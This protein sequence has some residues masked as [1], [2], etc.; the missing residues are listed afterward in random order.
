MYL[1]L[2]CLAANGNIIQLQKIFTLL[3]NCKQQQRLSIKN[4]LTL[5]FFL[6][7]GVPSTDILL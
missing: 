7:L 4:V 1:P 6:V 3:K 2:I 5:T